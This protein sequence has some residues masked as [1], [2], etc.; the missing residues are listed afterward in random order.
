MSVKGQFGLNYNIRLRAIHRE[1]GELLDERKIHNLVVDSGLG[2]V[3]Q[4]INGVGST[5]F[6]VIGIGE[7]TTSPVAG[8]V[9]LETE[10]TR[11]TATSITNDL[12]NTADY[13]HTFTFGSGQSFAIT[14]LGLFDSATVSGS[15]MLNRSTFTAVN[16]DENI[17][18]IADVTITVS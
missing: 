16:V 5:T 14:E 7:G 2:A 18:L 15:T 10:A 3:A 8:D 9:Q 1:T 11:A 13:S 4:L 17:D 12:F 6:T